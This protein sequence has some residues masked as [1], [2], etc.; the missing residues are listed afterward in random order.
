MNVY[1]REMLD[2]SICPA[3]G[4]EEPGP[5]DGSGGEAGLD[6]IWGSR[7]TLRSKRRDWSW[8]QMNIVSD[9]RKR[10]LPL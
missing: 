8:K 6:D 2:V 4:D 7:Q 9:V 3:A 5:A 10:K 1:T